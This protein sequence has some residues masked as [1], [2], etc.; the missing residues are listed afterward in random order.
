[1]IKKNSNFQRYENK[2]DWDKYICTMTIE[3]IEQRDRT[4]K[5]NLRNLNSLL[6]S[7]KKFI[8]YYPNILEKGNINSNEQSLNIYAKN[9]H[10]NYQD[11][12]SYIDLSNSDEK[13]IRNCAVGLR[14]QNLMIK[15]IPLIDMV[16]YKI[17]YDGSVITKQWLTFELDQNQVC[18]QKFI[19]QDN[20]LY[21]IYNKEILEYIKPNTYIK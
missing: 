15:D 7:F 6:A 20:D 14:I 21:Q 13:G 19:H 9:K 18:W 1:M 8:D 4:Q 5:V 10:L 12:Y 16:R 11:C 3:Q 2:S 17:A